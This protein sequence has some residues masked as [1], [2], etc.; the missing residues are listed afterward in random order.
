MAELQRQLA[1]LERGRAQAAAEIA[2]L[3]QENERALLVTELLATPHPTNP[4]AFMPDAWAR[5]LAGILVQ[6]DNAP[7]PMQASADG[8]RQEPGPSLRQQVR[9]LTMAFAGTWPER[10]ERGS[11]LRPGEAPSDPEARSAELDR[12]AQARIVQAGQAGTPMD[13]KDAVRA[14][15]KERP[16]LVS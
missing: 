15:V 8:T 1:E 14:I 4:R 12:L 3:R 2:G 16:D 6:I 13:Y 9:D 10:G 7:G 5:Q 11:D